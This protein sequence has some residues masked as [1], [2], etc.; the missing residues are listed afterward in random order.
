MADI[1]VNERAIEAIV[2]LTRQTAVVQLAGGDKSL[3]FAVI[4]NDCKIEDL[5]RLLYNEHNERPERKKGT[6]N[7]LDVPSFC[8][9]YTLFD[10]ENSRVFADET[11]AKVLAVLDYH[12]TG[13]NAPRWGQHRIDLTL[14][15]SEE[16]KLWTA[17]SGKIKTQTE[18]AEF[19]ESNGP[20][21]VKPDAATMLEV[22]RDLSAKT[23]GD[24]SSA[25]RLQNGSIQFRYSEQIKASVGTGQMEVPESFEVSI[26]VYIG[27][28][29]VSLTARLRYRI[30]SGKLTF[31][32]DLLRSDAVLR[33]AFLALRG[34]IEKSLGIKV[35]NGSPA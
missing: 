17:G 34:E 3:P 7:V 24:F 26:P 31:W 30:N 5:S 9:Y 35:I 16:W 12:A 10:D 25:V 6:V 2:K 13:D 20:D 18:F 23:E 29:K 14:R 1:T 32:Y 33:A 11:K 4:P 28:E 19:I 27:P 15:A 22:A 8:E 21:I